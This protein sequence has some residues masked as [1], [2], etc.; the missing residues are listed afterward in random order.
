MHPLTKEFQKHREYLL[1]A[2]QQERLEWLFNYY[3]FYLVVQEQENIE[4]EIW[5]KKTG[6]LPL[7]DEE[8]LFWEGYCFTK[9]S[10]YSSVISELYILICKTNEEQHYSKFFQTQNKSLLNIIKNELNLNG[11]LGKDSQA[12][13]AAYL[14][15]K[16]SISKTDIEIAKNR[17]VKYREETQEHGDIYTLADSEDPDKKRTYLKDSEIKNL[18]KYAFAFFSFIRQIFPERIENGLPIFC[19]SQSPNPPETFD[20]YLDDCKEKFRFW[21]KCYSG[22]CGPIS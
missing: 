4:K 16:S 12:S 10:F 6:K 5:R 1:L 20:A 7:K 15:R 19:L 11:V 14:L 8:V 18:V 3:A 21:R 22:R 9:R 13:S 2:A 17:L